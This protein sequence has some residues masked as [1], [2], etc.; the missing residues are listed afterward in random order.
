MEFINEV[1]VMENQILA[2]DIIKEYV[3]E[4]QELK[5]KIEKLLADKQS[6]IE[7]KNKL[8][9]EVKYLNR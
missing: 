5:A 2:K 1:T 7:E 3:L 9:E 6:L 8:L 4:N